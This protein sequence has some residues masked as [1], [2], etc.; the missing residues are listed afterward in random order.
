MAER[1]KAKRPYRSVR[2]AEQARRTQ[3][4]ILE[5]ARTL[6]L[7]RGFAATTIVAVAENAGVAPETVYAAYRTKAGLLEGVVDEAV[8]RDDAPD[9]VLE[10]RWVRDLLELPDLAARLAAL[11]RHT[12]QTVE[13][14]SPMH[15]VISAAGTG[16][17]E[18][19]GLQKRLQDKRFSDHAKIMKALAGGQGASPQGPQEAADTFSALAS[20]ELHRILTTDRG[21]SQE[22]YARWL[23][24]TIEAILLAA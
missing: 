18:L 8:L 22:R 20:P 5:A 3:A 7:E 9:E 19:D 2:R 15:A 24:R 12:A 17:A 14:T 11:A 10:R 21:W 1:V 13:L 4:R 6:F 16:A 23:E